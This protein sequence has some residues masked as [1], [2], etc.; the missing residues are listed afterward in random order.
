MSKRESKGK[1]IKPTFFIFCEGET[2]EEYVKFL[3]S[4]YLLPSEIDTKIA[5]SEISERYISK[6]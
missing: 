5:G 3:R 6:F 1:K 4:I 2:E